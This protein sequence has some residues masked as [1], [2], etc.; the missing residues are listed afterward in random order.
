MH[1]IGMAHQ[2]VQC[3]PV[4]VTTLLCCLSIQERWE[5]GKVGG[6]GRTR[7]QTYMSVF[8]PH[9]PHFVQRF[10]LKWSLG[11]ESWRIERVRGRRVW[12]E[13]GLQDWRRTPGGL[14]QGGSHPPRGGLGERTNPRKIWKGSG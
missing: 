1:E 11:L 3:M 9:A 2:H 12:Q 8:D 7:G 10:N 13:Q 14:W 4:W 6:L 5:G